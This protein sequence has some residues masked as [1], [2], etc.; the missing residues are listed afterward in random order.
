MDYRQ[1]AGVLGEHKR[2]KV[3]G[4]LLSINPIVV[5]VVLEDNGLPLFV[6]GEEEDEV[7][8]V[9]PPHPGKWE[10]HRFEPV[11]VFQNLLNL[12][13]YGLH[14]AGISSSQLLENLI[15]VIPGFKG[16]HSFQTVSLPEIGDTSDSDDWFSLYLFQFL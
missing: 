9:D 5:L 14:L 11:W 3:K 8:E 16:V 13:S 7:A 4:I 15:H 2:V 6:D 10:M 12:S 1:G